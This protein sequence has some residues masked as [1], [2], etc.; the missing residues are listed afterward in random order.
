MAS[1]GSLNVCR[2][3][4]QRTSYFWVCMQEEIK[5]WCPAVVFYDQEPFDN[6]KQGWTI[7]PAMRK[8]CL[9]SKYK[10]EQKALLRIVRVIQSKSPKMFLVLW[11]EHHRWH[12]SFWIET[13]FLSLAAKIIA[14]LNAEWIP[15]SVSRWRTTW[16][17]TI[18]QQ[19]CQSHLSSVS[20]PDLYTRVHAYK[21]RCMEGSWLSWADW[22]LDAQNTSVLS[23]HCP[24]PMSLCL[25]IDHHCNKSVP[26]ETCFCLAR[27]SSSLIWEAKELKCYWQHP[28]SAH[29]CRCSGYLPLRIT[30]TEV[31]ALQRNR[32]AN[33]PGKTAYSSSLKFS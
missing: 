17:L 10:L 4:L 9:P 32:F 2:Y 25:S 31:C 29:R 11:T 12:Y 16:W 18:S 22:I 3:N 7:C 23:L 14:T 15:N 28:L 20:H 26:L 19:M 21:C 5:Y 8:W 24:S 30:F 1:S 6:S 33:K 27:V 13:S